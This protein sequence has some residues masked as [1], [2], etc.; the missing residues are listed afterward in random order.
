MVAPTCRGR[1]GRRTNGVWLISK[2]RNG[3]RLS[4]ALSP[5][6]AVDCRGV[7]FTQEL[8]EELK[9]AVDNTFGDALFG[10]ARFLERA[11]FESVTFAGEAF[12]SRTQIFGEAFFHYAQFSHGAVFV[13]AEVEEK[14]TFDGATF[15]QDA[16]FAGARFKGDAR[17]P[18]T[19]FAQRLAGP[20]VC[21]GVFDLSQSVLRAPVRIRIAAARLDLLAAQIDAAVS[22]VVR[23]VDVHM[24]DV[25]LSQPVAINFHPRWIGSTR[26]RGFL[27]GVTAEPA[28]VA[29]LVAG[30]RACSSMPTGDET[31]GPPYELWPQPCGANATVFFRPCST[32]PA[33]MPPVTVRA[34]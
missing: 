6:A 15:G 27:E 28:R 3:A 21:G 5:G 29:W 17:F 26:V 30:T 9:T 22:L 2:R 32:V 24:Q 33:G 23:Y 19:E 11:D 12:F 7:P 25:T 8:L 16:V 18:G 1:R 20:I 4:G 34:T 13:S 31:A 14:A 10:R